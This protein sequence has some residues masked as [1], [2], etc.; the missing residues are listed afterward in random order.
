[1]TTPVR[2]P[3]L[4]DPDAPQI[5]R[6]QDAIGNTLRPV[7]Q[8]LSVTPIMG[9][10]LPSWI[11]PDLKADF[12]NVAGRTAGYHKNA[13]SYVFGRGRVSTAAGQAGG[14]TI[15]TLPSMYRPGLNITFPIPGSAGFQTLTI[16]TSGVVSVDAAIAAGGTVDLLFCFLAEL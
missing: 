1:M 14:T 11:Q 6:A 10:A 15:Y 13:L 7:A 4:R 2:F 16:T 9:A 3:S 5:S 8:A 12:I